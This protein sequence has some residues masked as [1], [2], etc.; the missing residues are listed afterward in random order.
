MTITLQAITKLAR[1]EF[2][3]FGFRADGQNVE[4]RTT[5]STIIE[6]NAEPATGQAAF[7]QN[8]VNTYVRLWGNPKNNEIVTEEPELV[9][10]LGVSYTH[11][12]S[13]SN[14]YTVRYLIK[15]ESSF[16]D[17]VRLIRDIG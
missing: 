5:T 14:G 15:K 11:V 13:G 4:Y 2:R 12:N 8:R 3:R 6:F 16:G 7:S 1:F 17:S 9:V 10:D